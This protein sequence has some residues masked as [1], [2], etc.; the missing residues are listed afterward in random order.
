MRTLE[1]YLAVACALAI[2][3]PALFGVR[4]RRG[5][6]AITMVGLVMAQWLVEG[7]RWPLLILYVVALGLAVGDFIAVERDLPWFRRIGRGIFGLLGLGLVVAPTVLLPVPT[8]PIPSGPMAI[9]TR[10]VEIQAT[11]EPD[12]FG[13]TRGG[14]RRFAAQIWYPAQPEEGTEPRPWEPD[15]GVVAPAL[16]HNEGLP[17]FF[18]NHLR[19]TDSHSYTDA[20]VDEGEFPLLIYSH[21]W[22][23][24]KTVAL[25]QI[26]SLVSQ[27]YVVVAIDHAYG[28]VATVVN[29]EE[30]PLD[31]EFL[32]PPEATQKQKSE[33]ETAAIGTFAGDIS[34]VLD[35][36]DQGAI[37]V[38]SQFSG[39]ID[40]E[41]IGVWGH[42][43]GGGAAL[44]I[45]LTDERCG[46]V[47]AFDP[48][49]DTLPDP[50]LATTGVRPM[51]LMR[52][53]PWRGTEN[54]A[55]LRGIVARSRTLTYWL[56]VLGAD[57]SDFVAAPL[58][59]PVGSRLGLKGP[60]DGDRVIMI[61]HRYLSGFFDRFLAGTGP[62]ALDTASYSEV[63]V[64]IIDNRSSGN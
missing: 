15:I 21:G 52:S 16:A 4:T 42:G 26:E 47:A 2:A 14:G 56:D 11:L 48:V 25:D 28:A 19:Y 54:D 39:S 3:W 38:F 62:A 37:G 20:P 57:T 12:S 17:G 30:I 33:A 61:N 49:V 60:I 44:Q 45:C 59:S 27:G 1:I 8:L 64:D 5:L 58:I 13:T 50:V 63:D 32:S 31:V 29:G 36:M 10:T 43:F 51:L 23:E 9:G 18:F 22:G 40:L 34:A 6:V 41:S 7:Y 35:E 53:D 24:F 46:A 55:V